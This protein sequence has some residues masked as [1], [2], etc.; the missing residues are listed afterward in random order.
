MKLGAFLL[1]MVEPLIGRILMA[2]GLSLVTVVGFDQVVGVLQTQLITS[3]NS[4]PSQ[5]LQLFLIAGG[6]TGISMIVAA[7]AVR[8]ML[9]QA[10]NAK[11]LLGASPS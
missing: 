5:M 10:M 6:G 7:I 4:L 2:L 1:S 11:K 3:V 8:V 9:W